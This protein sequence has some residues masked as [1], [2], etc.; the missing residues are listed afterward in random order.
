MLANKQLIC[1]AVDNFPL[2]NYTIKCSQNVSQLC[3][4]RNLK[5]IIAD[6]SKSTENSVFSL[7]AWLQ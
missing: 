1:G 2:H 5:K 3:P 4:F 7:P 6:K